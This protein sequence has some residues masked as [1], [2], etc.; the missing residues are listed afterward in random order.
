MNKPISDAEYAPEPSARRFDRSHADRSLL[1]GRTVAIL[2][3]GNQGHAHALNLRDSG[4]QVVV[5]LREGSARWSQ[6]ADQGL[7]VTSVEEASRRGQI[8]MFLLPDEVQGRVYDE[9]V[10]P[11][12]E[13]GDVLA[14]A[15]GFA[16]AFDQVR[17]PADQPAI[18]IAPKGQGHALRQAFVAGGGLP[19]LL[20]VEGPHPE[21]SLALALAYADACGALAGGAT[22]TTFREEA[23]T[24]QFGEQAVLCGGMVELIQAAFET[25]TERGYSPE[26]AYFECLHEVKII[27]DLIHAHGVDGMRTMI[28]STAAYGGLRA[29]RRVIGEESRTAMRALLSDIE[30]G[31]FARD[32]L[33]EQNHGSPE[34]AQ[35]VEEEREHLMQR[36]G[37]GLRRFLDDCRLT[38]PRVD[39]RADP[40]VDRETE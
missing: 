20:A 13:A 2:G 21:E 1:A 36:T 15:H 19:S 33:A 23:V 10:A 39:P 27:A 29:G 3:Y 26:M 14:F 17:P 34:L 37:R 9:Q 40:H 11:Q 16:L 22:L 6:A 8:I 5:G 28:S 4:V 31:R 30:E 24:D 38:D 32:F 35:Q 25:L 7:M 18:L 12:L